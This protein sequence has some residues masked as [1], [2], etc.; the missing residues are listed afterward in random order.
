MVDDEAFKLT[1]SERAMAYTVFEQSNIGHQAQGYWLQWS[2]CWQWYSNI[3][4]L[5]IVE[6][7]RISLCGDYTKRPTALNSGRYKPG[8]D[9]LT[10]FK[11]LVQ[12]PPTLTPHILSFATSTVSR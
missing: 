3:S 6:C 2:L 12:Y 7:F 11:S 5:V 9:R 8:G 4:R 1:S 10:S